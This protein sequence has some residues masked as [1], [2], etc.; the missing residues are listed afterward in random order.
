MNQA[1]GT[2]E[3]ID[4]FCKLDYGT[5][6]PRFKKIDVNGQNEA[7][8]YTW[9]KSQKGGTLGKSIK[10]NFAKFLVDGNGNVVSRYAPTTKPEEIAEK[11]QALLNQKG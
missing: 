8:L 3:E 5:T 11:I 9:L 10:W 7:P 4:S 6:F 2:D 1:P